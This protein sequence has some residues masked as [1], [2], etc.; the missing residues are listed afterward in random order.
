MRR[1]TWRFWWTALVLLTL[2]RLGF[3]AWQWPRVSA[4]NGL[5]PVMWGGLRFDLVIL[6]MM[7]ALPAGLSPWFGQ[8]ALAERLT[9]WWYRICWFLL[10]FF[11]VLTPQFIIEYDSRPN[12]IFFQY[13][14]HPRE[15]FGMIWEGY[16][17]VLIGALALI[18]LLVWIGFRLLRPGRPD[19]ALRWWLRPIVCLALVAFCVMSIRGTLDHRP[20]NAATVAFGNDAMVNTLPLSGF[21]NV[22][23][24]AYMATNEK[25]AF[26]LYGKMP[27]EEA[28]RL[29]REAAGLEGAPM[30][31]RLPSLHFQRS[32]SP[33]DK[34]LN[35]V[36]IIQESLGAQYS[37]RLGGQG[38]T[39]ALDALADQGWWFERAYA[40]GTRSVRGLEAITTGF[41]PT[42][43]DAVLI[44]P[45]AETGFFTL[46]ELLGRHGYFSRFVYG[47]EA[48]FDNMRSFF[49]GNGFDEVVDRPKFVA[50]QF[51]GSWGASDEDMFNQVDR[52]LRDDA[53]AGR[54]TL[55]VAFSVSNH[56]PWEYPPGRIEPQGDPATVANTV[57]YADWALGEFFRKAPEAPYWENTVFL[58]VADHDARVS[59]SLVP[60]RHFHIPALILGP[61]IAPKSD[62]Q[63]ISQVDLAPTLLSLIGLDTVHPMLGHDLTRGGG[64]RAMMQFGDNYGYLSGDRLVVLEPGKPP[65]NSRYVAPAEYTPVDPDPALE[66]EALAHVLWPSWAYAAE[67][68]ALPPQPK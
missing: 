28:T 24:A 9:V 7:I 22:V 36:I 8:F 37:A 64:N 18:G 17:G 48:H 49:L 51:V 55:T 68:Y 42:P 67:R 47:G 14:G 21:W 41:L 19:R 43:A 13:L 1:L 5:W 39:P 12:R 6:G 56:S 16:R 2:A 15:V 31:A 35:L 46:G 50:P 60:V 63:I 10:V 32:T 23:N 44:L 58:I 62:R 33:R 45:K 30:D 57:R 20:I 54:R 4:V 53:R 59:G 65:R 26:D 52:L 11:E 25:S 61:G 40:T 29:V 66:R 3:V 27:V 38:L 34:P